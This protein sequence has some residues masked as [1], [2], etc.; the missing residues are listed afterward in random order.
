MHK[1]LTVSQRIPSYHIREITAI[2][3]SAQDYLN[4]HSFIAEITLNKQNNQELVAK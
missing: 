4:V 3:K 1:V 2:P